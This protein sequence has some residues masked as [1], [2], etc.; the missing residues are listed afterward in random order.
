MKSLQAQALTR[1]T[2]QFEVLGIELK[3]P[4][5]CDGQGEAGRLY[6]RPPWMLVVFDRWR[7]KYLENQLQLVVPVEVSVPELWD[8]INDAA[9]VWPI[10]PLH[11]GQPQPQPRPPMQETRV[12]PLADSFDPAA[13]RAVRP[14]QRERKICWNGACSSYGKLTSQVLVR[15]RSTY[16]LWSCDECK[17]WSPVRRFA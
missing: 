7:E 1:L 11:Y 5:L 8:W 4:R 2:S 14:G 3:P 16:Q 10:E 13:G 17:C 15:N 6:L 9:G 12:G